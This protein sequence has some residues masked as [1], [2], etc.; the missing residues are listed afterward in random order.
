[1]VGHNSKIIPDTHT[2][3]CKWKIDENAKK[4]LMMKKGRKTKEIK[5]PNGST[6]WT[7]KNQSFQKK[8][9]KQIIAH[10]HTTNGTKPF[11]STAKFE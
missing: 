2:H 9:R 10:A 6:K 5:K 1:M 7:E 11:N 3:T 8:N 4:F